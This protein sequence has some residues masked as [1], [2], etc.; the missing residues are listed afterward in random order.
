[1][2]HAAL[3]F[4]CHYNGLSIIQELGIHGIECIAMDNRRSIG[5]FSKY[6]KYVKCPDPSC[7]EE[8]FIAFLFDY[9]SKEKNKPVL[10]PTNDHWAVALSKHKK[11]LSEVSIPCVADWETIEIFIHKDK[12]YQIGQER[13]Y[14]TPKTWD[15]K[16]IKNITDENFPIVA[17]PIFRR[18][19]SNSNITNFT[20]NMDRLRLTL[21][22]TKNELNAFLERESSFIEHLVFQEYVRG[23]SDSM[24]TVGIYADKNA[25]IMGLFTGHKVRG[26][27]AHN[28]DCVVGEKAPVPDY[29]I[30]NTKRIVKDF[31][32]CGIAEFEYKIDEK[33]AQYKLIEINPRSWSWIGITPACG[34]S[35]PLIAYNDLSNKSFKPVIMNNTFKT[36]KFIII[37][38]DLKNSLFLY[39]YDNPKWLK[40]FHSWKNDIR[41]DTLVVAEYNDGDWPILLIALSRTFLNL[42]WSIFNKL[43]KKT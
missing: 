34:V 3:I 40:S 17:K 42:F 38:E 4:D 35:L 32:Y 22:N 8:K 6:A 11:R 27:P 5:T 20:A 19:S 21:L 33:T 18:S 39:K 24:Y 16:S 2:I 10:F 12:F 13:G 1:M 37:I 7:D 29:I 43:F 31:H 15:N 36:V 9:C 23:M 30:N 28:G 26:Y 14:L 41:A 25:N